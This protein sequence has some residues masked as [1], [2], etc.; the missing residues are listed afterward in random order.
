MSYTWVEERLKNAPRRIRLSCSKFD[1]NDISYNIVTQRIKT[2]NRLNICYGELEGSDGLI[3]QIVVKI[4]EQNGPHTDTDLFIGLIDEIE[5]HTKIELTIGFDGYQSHML[6]WFAT[7]H[8]IGII[9]NDLGYPLDKIDMLQF[10]LKTKKLMCL[11]LVLQINYLQTNNIYHGDIKPPNICVRP[12]GNVA[13]ID[14]GIAYFETSYN[15]PFVSQIYYDT[16]ITSGSPEYAQIYRKQKNDEPFPKE[17]FDKSQ[18]WALAGLIF[19]ILIDNPKLYF[20]KSFELIKTFKL[21]NENLEIGNLSKRFSYFNEEF[22]NCIKKFI[23]A[24]LPPIYHKF[25]PIILNMFEYDHTKRA[26]LDVI[27]EQIKAI[28]LE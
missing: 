14:F 5:A 4:Y 9:F 21:P 15:K 18:H 6:Y 27:I 20:S 28:D 26:G 2:H 22:S 10:D 13:L 16:T 8:G 24:K 7:K 3:K 25:K 19:G 11:Q 17:L 1:F 23:E 12:D